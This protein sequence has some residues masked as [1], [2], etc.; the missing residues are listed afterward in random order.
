MTISISTIR[1]FICR[2]NCLRS[3]TLGDF[4]SLLRR[5]SNSFPKNSIRSEDWSMTNEYYQCR[6][7][8][9]IHCS[10][11]FICERK[12]RDARLNA[13]RS[14]LYLG[15]QETLSPAPTGVSPAPA[16]EQKHNENNDQDGF[17][18]STS[19]LDVNGIIKETRPY[20]CSH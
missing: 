9:E 16:T 15:G 11:Y 8:A 12:N 18:V 1:T 13:Q 10:L 5:D 20:I 3:S 4:L 2:S 19:L 6:R 17:H 7:P 14:R